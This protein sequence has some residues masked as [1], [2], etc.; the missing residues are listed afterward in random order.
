MILFSADAL[1]MTTS[2]PVDSKWHGGICS[3]RLARA[4]SIL[5][6][7]SLATPAKAQVA[8]AQSEIATI[9]QIID[10][11]ENQ[12]TLKCDLFPWHPFLDFAFRIQTGYLLSSNLAQ[13]TPGEQPVTYLR[14]TSEKA[15]PVVMRSIIELPPIPADV[16]L[17]KNLQDLKKARITTSGAFNIGE[18]RYEVELLLVNQ[19]GRSC[20]KRWHMQTD[21]SV[22]VAVPVA[23]GP[24]SVAPLLHDSWDG[25]LDPHGVRLSILLDAAP[26]NPLAPHLHTWDRTLL[27]QTLESLLQRIP[28]RSVQF[29]AFNLEQQ[30]E[31]FRQEKFD[32]DGFLKFSNLL[33]H[34]ELTSI[35][36]QA[37]QRGSTAR[38]LSKIVQEQISAPSP[39]DAVFFLGP[40]TRF[41]QKPAVENQEGSPSFFYFELHWPGAH[42][43]DSIEHLTKELHGSTFVITT[44]N[45]LAAAIRKTRSRLETVENGATATKNP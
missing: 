37:L 39:A 14:V 8:V 31:I 15:S 45:E 23:M 21:K 16:A 30:R 3:S 2:R 44:A 18:G 6:L 33:K 10:S 4:L 9:N 20:Y 28:C 11:K 29:V 5:G 13:F 12:N 38:F 35:S 17:T 43:P 26:M 24:Q 27:L 42:F 36:Y 1:R 22:H 25:K 34:L 41:D 19:Q 40:A 32:V 7:F